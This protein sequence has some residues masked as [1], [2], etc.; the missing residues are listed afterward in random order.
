MTWPEGVSISVQHIDEGSPL[1]F[2]REA[3]AFRRDRL[4][5]PELTGWDRDGD[6]VTLT[7]AKARVVLNFGHS[8]TPCETAPDFASGPCDGSVPG[9]T[10]AVW[11]TG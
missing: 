1:R 9:R 2:Y 6:V 10:G 8:E 11:L 4:G 3:F 7:Y 5:E